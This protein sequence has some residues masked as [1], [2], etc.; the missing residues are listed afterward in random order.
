MDFTFVVAFIPV[1]ER[2]RLGIRGH[3]EREGEVRALPF[4]P[5]EESD[6]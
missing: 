4:V 2:E 3:G 5:D 6:R 1:G